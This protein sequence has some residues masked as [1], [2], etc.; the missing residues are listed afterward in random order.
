MQLD[1]YHARRGFM[2]KT[3]N[4]VVY[5]D[6]KVFFSLIHFWTLLSWWIFYT[7]ADLLLFV[8]LST[9]KS[10]TMWPHHSHNDKHARCLQWVTLLWEWCSH[11]VVDLTVESRT[12]SRRSRLLSS[13]VG[14]PDGWFRLH[15]R[16]N[17]FCLFN[18]VPD[19]TTAM[20]WFVVCSV[21]DNQNISRYHLF[22]NAFLHV[23]VQGPLLHVHVAV[24]KYARS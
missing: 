23:F 2:Q 24:E 3:A 6:G 10:T 17:L 11:I 18:K 22:S 19:L 15:V 16:N 13:M 7:S 21:H 9:V 14:R 12:N 5:N 20:D 1:G 8:L 4:E